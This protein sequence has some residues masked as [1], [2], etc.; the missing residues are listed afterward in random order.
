MG[1][2]SDM[3]SCAA[4]RLSY[5]KTILL[6]GLVMAVSVG[7]DVGAAIFL[8]E[9][10]FWAA[11]LPF[12]LLAGLSS[13]VIFGGILVL[14]RDHREATGQSDLF[15]M[16]TNRP[17]KSRSWGV[18]QLLRIL[19]PWIRGGLLVGDI[20][21]IHSEA[22]IRRTLDADGALDGLPFM[23]EMLRYCGLQF[24]VFRCVDK[25][26][27]MNTK[28]GVRRLRDTVL[29]EG[30][31]CDGSAHDGCQAECH[32]LWKQAWLQKVSE[33]KSLGTA[34]RGEEGGGVAAL[35]QTACVGLRTKSAMDGSV[36]FCQMTE[37]LRAT[38]PMDW[39]DVRQDL[40]SVLLGNVGLMAFFVAALTRLF[41]AVQAFRGGC[42]YPSRPTS[43]LNSTPNKELGLKP[44]DRVLVKSKEAIAQ[45]L[46]ARDRNRGLRYDREMIRFCGGRFAVQR[47]VTK[48]IAEDSARMA[49][50]KTPCITLEGVTSTGEF[51]RFCPQNEYVFFREIWLERDS[52]VVPP[53]C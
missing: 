42:D 46:D 15:Y 48:L 25:I 18:R 12:S 53:S 16:L 11:F 33:F 2:E 45:T 29:L 35:S 27:D 17:A 47:S 41:N 32:I 34:Y 44:G 22:E 5:W 10:T 3:L 6:A 20:V 28:T 14:Y 13:A 9:A 26:N 52:S 31:R 1:V 40:R 21:K 4:H 39:W 7:G 50:M 49:T 51:L 37:L 24:R 30:L 8:R 36:Y 19:G 23:P 43:Y 38:E